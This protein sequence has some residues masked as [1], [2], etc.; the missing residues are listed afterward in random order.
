MKTYPYAKGVSPTLPIPLGIM[1]LNGRYRVQWG[2]QMAGLAV[3]TI[4]PLL[5]Y[6]IFQ[7]QFIRGLLAG[8][9]KG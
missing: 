8:A 4:P 1:F 7:R 9:L 2:L 3:A 6:I 5:I